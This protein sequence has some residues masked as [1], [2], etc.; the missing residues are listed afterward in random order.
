[1]DTLLFMKREYLAPDAYCH[2]LTAGR[3][4]SREVIASAKPPGTTSG[5]R[6]ISY[7]AS[8]GLNRML[9]TSW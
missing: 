4:S 5:R 8:A 1:M 9:H 7:S 3:D 2:Q 6:P